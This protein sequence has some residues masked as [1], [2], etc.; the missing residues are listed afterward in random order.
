ME[1]TGARPKPGW[2]APPMIP[3]LSDQSMFLDCL[4]QE[5]EPEVTLADA[6]KAS[7]AMLAAYKSASTGQVVMLPLDE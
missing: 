7:E 1:R 2:Y 5:K 3:A 4:E 6:A